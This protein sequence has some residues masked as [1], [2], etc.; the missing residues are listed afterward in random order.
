MTTQKTKKNLGFS[1]LEMVFYVSLFAII[2]LVLVK[3]TLSMIA[4]FRD[5]QVTADINQSS[6]VFERMAREIRQANSIDTI[7]TS[8]LKLNSEDS[9]GNPKTITFTLNGSN[10]E[11]RENDVLIGNLNPTNLSITS[12]SFTQITTS[13][14]TAV[15]IIMS[16]G[17]TRYN[18]GRTEEFNNTLVM[19]G[20]Y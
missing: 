13:N 7:S 17:S 20:S 10:L 4:A 3:A 19:R 14:S 18:S 9:S 8:N 2:S 16:V 12:I 1:L 6:Q 15:R 5:T 11:L